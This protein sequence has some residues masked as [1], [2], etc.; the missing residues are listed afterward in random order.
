M[1]KKIKPADTASPGKE[2]L[3]KWSNKIADDEL[4]LLHKWPNGEPETVEQRKLVFDDVAVWVARV[5]II[6]FVG[7]EPGEDKEAEADD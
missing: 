2:T 5:R 1:Q 4:T 7:T 3:Y 6:P